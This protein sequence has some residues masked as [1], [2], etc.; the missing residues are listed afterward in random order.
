VIFDQDKL[1]IAE[2]EAIC[3]RIISR[4]E[5]KKQPIEFLREEIVIKPQTEEEMITPSGKSTPFMVI[6]KDLPSEAKDFKVEI[7]EA[8][9]L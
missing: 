4:G 9:N 3:G 7:V 1:K 8:P 5:L 2:K 6:F